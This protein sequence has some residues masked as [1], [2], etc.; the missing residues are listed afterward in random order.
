[1]TSHHI[2]FTKSKLD[3]LPSADDGKRDY[4]YDDGQEGLMLQMTAK[5]AKTYYVYKRMQGRPQRLKLGKYTEITLIE[6]RKLAKEAVGAIAQGAN[7]HKER[8][9]VRDE[10]TFGELFT[11]FIEEYAKQHKS[12]WKE[13]ENTY[14]RYIRAWESKPI[15]QINRDDVTRIHTKVGKDN[16][17]Y[18]AN[19]LLALIRAVYN[20][21]IEWEWKSQNPATHI[22]PFKEKSRDRFLQPEEL[23]R[24]FE[25]LD[26]EPNI[27]VRDF[28]KMS[29]FTGA[30][31]TNVLEMKWDDI[32]L[33]A[34]TWR[35]PITKNG[36][37]QT[38][39]LP[40]EAIDIIK[41]R[42]AFVDSEWVF[43]SNQTNEKH[44]TDPKKT[45]KTLIARASIQDLR[46]HDLR[47]TMGSYQAIL[48]ANSFTIGR[49]L[50]HKT[51][52]ATEIYA[53]MNLDPIRE[54]MSQAVKTMVQH[55]NKEDE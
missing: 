11:K 46:I 48:G 32:S 21:A 18:S 37:S 50:G 42:K 39:P 38:V 3:T 8:K 20:K 31:K 49:S 17:I 23:K 1:M 14:N 9:S 45:W 26:T 55:A 13:D 22:K 44:L 36:Q 6:A 28:I 43:P 16:G 30:R 19:R 34:G 5:G 7:P 29:L 40:I 2:N 41:T 47:R 52:Q 12:T 15:S 54:S 35:I 33:Q 4:Y 10:M 51:Q 27:V 24:F 53:R 25:A